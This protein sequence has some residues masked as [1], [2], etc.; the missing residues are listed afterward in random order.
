MPKINIEKPYN[1]GLP[2]CG[3]HEG[4]AGKKRGAGYEATT[5]VL[6]F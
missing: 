6:N 2:S 1:T 5:G 3:L 4:K